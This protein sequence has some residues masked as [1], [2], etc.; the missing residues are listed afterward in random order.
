[1]VMCANDGYSLGMTNFACRIARSASARGEKDIDVIQ[2]LKEYAGK[3]PGLIEKLG[4]DFARGHQQV[5][6]LHCLLDVNIMLTKSLYRMAQASGGIVR[7]EDFETLWNC[8]RADGAKSSGNYC[9]RIM[10]ILYLTGFSKL[11]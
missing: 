11:Q 3:V 1:M 8:I 9:L 5:S 2:M 10:L 6:L 7:T 4:T